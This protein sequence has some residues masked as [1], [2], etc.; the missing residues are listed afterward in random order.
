ML[1]SECGLARSNFLGGSFCGGVVLCNICVK[2]DVRVYI[3]RFNCRADEALLASL[4][5]L[6]LRI[7]SI[8]R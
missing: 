2:K 1:R 5:F 4:G 7:D 6:A 8:Y 3:F